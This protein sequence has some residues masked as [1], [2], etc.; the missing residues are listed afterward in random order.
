MVEYLQEKEAR[1]EQQTK[2]DVELIERHLALEERKHNE[3]MVIEQNKLILKEKELAI[4][5]EDREKRD[6]ELLSSMR[7]KSNNRK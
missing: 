1:E 6:R 7:K 5:Q 4:Q 2:I 3:A